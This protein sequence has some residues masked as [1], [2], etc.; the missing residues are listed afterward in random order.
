MYPQ[1]ERRTNLENVQLFKKIF[2][3][4]S[5]SR[6]KQK[7]IKLDGERCILRDRH[8]HGGGLHN[9]LNCSLQVRSTQD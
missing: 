5:I 3:R 4:N 9:G 1:Y 7:E 8:L 6:Q 2:S